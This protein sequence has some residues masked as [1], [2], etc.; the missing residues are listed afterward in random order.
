MQGSLAVWLT[1]WLTACLVVPWEKAM[2]VGLF[3]AV[4]EVLPHPEFCKEYGEFQPGIWLPLLAKIKGP[5][6]NGIIPLAAA[7]GFL[8]VA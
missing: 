8:L 3:A 5:F 4:A 6:D 7:L 1:A 2:V